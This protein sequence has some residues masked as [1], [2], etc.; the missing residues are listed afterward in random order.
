M[1]RNKNTVTP[2]APAPAPVPAQKTLAEL[3]QQAHAI[4][5]K[6]EQQIKKQTANIEKYVR[7]IAENKMRGM[8]ITHEVKRITSC[9]NTIATYQVRKACIDELIE[10]R[11]FLDYQ[12]SYITEMAKFVNDINV[13]VGAI[14]VPEDISRE[15]ARLGARFNE[16]QSKLNSMLEQIDDT[17]SMSLGTDDFTDLDREVAKKL[18]E[19]Y[20]LSR[21]TENISTDEFVAKVMNSLL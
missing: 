21:V 11:E 6:Y 19:A 9:R 2:P 13:A 17:M 4:Q 12:M 7:K 5:F 18:E 16:E 14:D 15:I 10:R 1:P 8:P 3:K 20:N